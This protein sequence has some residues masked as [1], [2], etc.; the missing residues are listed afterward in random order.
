MVRASSASGVQALCTRHFV[1]STNEISS[2]DGVRSVGSC[3]PQRSAPLEGLKAVLERLRRADGEGAGSTAGAGGGEPAEEGRPA[4]EVRVQRQ[5][6]ARR[7]L[8]LAGARAVA[9]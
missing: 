1:R 2:D 9:V 8:R 7:E 3:M 6:G 4:V 5:A